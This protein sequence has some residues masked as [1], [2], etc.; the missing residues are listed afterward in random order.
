M[1]LSDADADVFPDKATTTLHYIT[2]QLG[3]YTNADADNI[4]ADGSEGAENVALDETDS[5]SGE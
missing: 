4:G 1:M 3:T 5:D 2:L